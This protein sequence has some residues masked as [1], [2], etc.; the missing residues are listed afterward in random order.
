MTEQLIMM[1]VIIAAE[2]VVK[3]RKDNN[4][5]EKLDKLE[6]KVKQLENFW[7]K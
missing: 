3:A 1:A 5:E 2:E 4:L 6:Q 7:K